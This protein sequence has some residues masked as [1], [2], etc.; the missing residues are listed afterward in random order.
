M[1][2]VEYNRELSLHLNAMV[3]HIDDALRFAY[4]QPAITD[5]L[6]IIKNKEY[7]LNPLKN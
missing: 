4:V 3:K 5:V 6:K 1:T 7:N 2:R